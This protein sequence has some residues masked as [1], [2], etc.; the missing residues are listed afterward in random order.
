MNI[1][2]TSPY[3]ILAGIAIITLIL[4]Y[5]ESYLNNKKKTMST[6]IKE[7]G[8]VVI[9]AGVLMYFLKGNFKNLSIPKLGVNLPDSVS[10][11]DSI[12]PKVLSEGGSILTGQPDF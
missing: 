2:F 4:S 5:S 3:V 1:P 10:V 12:I 11:S 8:Y 7:T 9:V 6:Y